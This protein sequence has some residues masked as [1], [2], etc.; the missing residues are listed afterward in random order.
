MAEGAKG[1]NIASFLDISLVSLW[2][3]MTCGNDIISV[4]WPLLIVDTVTVQCKLKR[5]EA[6]CAI[7]IACSRL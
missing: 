7:A 2:G 3:G 5:A 4:E 6:L 1:A